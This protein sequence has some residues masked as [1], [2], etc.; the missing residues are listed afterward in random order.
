G[1]RTRT[2]PRSGSSRFGSSDSSSSPW[3]ASASGL[4]SSSGKTRGGRCRRRSWAERPEDMADRPPARLA[5]A[6][7]A[8]GLLP[9][10]VAQS[11]RDAVYPYRRAMVDSY[12]YRGRAITGSPF[13]SS[14]RDFHGYPFAVHG[15][16]D[17]RNVALA[18]AV[19]RPGDTILEI[20]AN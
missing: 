13:T 19:V 15:F 10:L 8:C 4:R 3:R 18:L 1:T 6:R 7:L 16:Y 17:W 2:R 9:P 20:G 14:T 12:A 11:A 5:L